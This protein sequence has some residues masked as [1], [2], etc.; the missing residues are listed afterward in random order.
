MNDVIITTEEG[1]VTVIESIEIGPQGPVGP[2]GPQGP[3]GPV[4]P[5]GPQ[6]P[7]G[8]GV[9]DGEI[10]FTPKSG[11]TGPVGTVYF[12]SDDEHLWVSITS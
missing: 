7:Q 5:V 9:V 12:D 8:E 10:H 11:S 1:V 3:Q 4:G 2:V 6:G